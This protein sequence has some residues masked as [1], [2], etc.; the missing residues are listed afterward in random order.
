[1]NIMS[2]ALLLVNH[3]GKIFSLNR[4]ALSLLEYEENELIGQPVDIIFSQKDENTLFE[5][6]RLNELVN[7]RHIS[8]VETAFETKNGRIV[9]I[10]LAISAMRD[11][12]DQFRGIVFIG[13][14]ITE[15]KNAEEKIREHTENLET[16]V[17]ER[18]RALR[19]SE[20]KLQAILSGIGDLMTMQNMR[21]E[22]IWINQPMKD[23]YGDAIIGTKCYTT[24]KGLTEPCP[25]CVIEKVFNQEQIIVS[26]KPIKLVD[27]RQIHALTTSSPVRDTQGNIVAVVEIAKDITESKNA[28]KKL[29]RTLDE[30]SRSNI[31]LERF[32]YIASHD[33]Q[34]PLRMIVSFLQ[35]LEHRY[36]GKLDKDADD[37]IMFAVDGA[38]RMQRMI[39]DL[40]AYSRVGTRG[41]S[42]EITDCNTV[43]GLAIANLKVAIEENNVIISHESLPT[44]MADASQLILVFQNLIG[45]AIKFRGEE[46]PQVNVSAKYR[47]TEWVFSVRDNGIGIDP[48]YFE[49]I[50]L[51]FQ[52]LN[53]REEYSGSGIG[54]AICKKIIERHGGRIW[55]DSQPGKGSTFYF[56]IPSGGAK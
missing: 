16:I 28:E 4:A 14:D 53:N 47:E 56:A 49:R 44:L 7:L 31:E 51:I 50:F 22:I 2:D 17:K 23:M 19:E 40:L 13:R 18:T 52:R 24:Y 25:D 42:F 29:K 46:T 37:F 55:V 15:H 36:K 6:T 33:L 41:G 54:L 11:N 34:E 30:L 9:P 32:A 45:N 20:E 26:E 5:G 1:M 8:D 3:D 35:L 39:D 27:G 48:E 10:S 12:D 43:L 38:I 21:R